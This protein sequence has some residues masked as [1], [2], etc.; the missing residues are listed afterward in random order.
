MLHNT[1]DAFVVNASYQSGNLQLAIDIVDT[2]FY[3]QYHSLLCSEIGEEYWDALCYLFTY[4]VVMLLM[5]TLMSSFC[6]KFLLD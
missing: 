6:M 2:S 4:R 5:V 1:T 3:D